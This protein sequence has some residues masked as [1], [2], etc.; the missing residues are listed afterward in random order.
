MPT[1][2]LLRHARSTANAAGVL[3]G[4]SPGVHLDDDGRG[5]AREVAERLRDLPLVHVAMSPLERCRETAAPLLELK[6]DVTTSTE[7]D[8]GECHYGAWTGRPLAEL[9]K[10]PLWRTVQDEPSRATFPAS[11]EHEGES[12]T[13]MAARTVAAIERIDA[14]VAHRH[15]PDA[16]WLALS[17]G[18]PLKA[19]LAHAAGAPLDAFQRWHV[20]PASVSL[21]RLTDGRATLLRVN[22]T[23]APLWRPAPATGLA[24]GDATV[25]GATA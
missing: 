17:H 4:W 21:I 15:G 14:E 25:G 5:Q 8:L 7:A 16:L 9:A 10:E 2:I 24:S 18:D 23:G 19:V 12:L 22:D 1:V 3:A 6:P 11:A 13:A 20:A